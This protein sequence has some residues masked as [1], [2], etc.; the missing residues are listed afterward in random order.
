MYWIPSALFTVAQHSLTKSPTALEAL[1]C[2]G[3]AQRQRESWFKRVRPH[4]FTDREAGAVRERL[5]KQA[6]AGRAPAAPLQR[7]G[8]AAPGGEVEGPSRAHA[9]DAGGK[10][11]PS[12]DVLGPWRAIFPL[13]E[14]PER[15][16]AGGATPDLLRRRA[17]LALAASMHAMVSG[18]DAEEVVLPR[19][20]QERVDA[21][22]RDTPWA[23]DEAQVCNL[24]DLASGA[25]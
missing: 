8:E 15:A 9:P 21:A 2:T 3:L 23:G 1:G 22:S 12:E 17:A 16:R 20:L 25:K 24:A 10:E 19:R 11:G 14:D 4:S 5:R 7:L 13:F 18:P 6:D